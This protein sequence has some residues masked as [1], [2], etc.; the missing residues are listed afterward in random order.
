MSTEIKSGKEIL[1]TFF[2]EVR[3]DETLDSDTA[4]AIL[5]LSVPKCTTSTLE[6]PSRLIMSCSALTQTGQPA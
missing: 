6:T 3:A 4:S 1:D 2:E 5:D